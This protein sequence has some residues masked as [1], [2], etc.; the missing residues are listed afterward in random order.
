MNAI[1][2]VCNQQLQEFFSLTDGVVRVGRESDNNIQLMD[3]S[4]SRHHAQLSNMP[5]TCEVE[6]RSSANGTFV[7]G[8]RVQTATLRHGDEVRFGE[9]VMRFEEVSH[10][11]HDDLGKGRNYSP[12]SQHSTVR[13]QRHHDDTRAPTPDT[14]TKTF[15][16][17]PAITI[18]K[19]EDS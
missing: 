8:T 5:N 17:P 10:E 3:D 14:E 16:P 1:L 6:D 11:V 4:V 13:V 7:N 2:V 18:K 12:L 19:K 15:A 9:T